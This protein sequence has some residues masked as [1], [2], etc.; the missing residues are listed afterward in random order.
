MGR[1][2]RGAVGDQLV[3]GKAAAVLLPPARLPRCSSSSLTWSMALPGE[4]P[5]A[6]WSREKV[7]FLAAPSWG[8]PV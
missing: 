8:R 6:R 5:Q 4:P 3:L 2:G 7:V 1:T